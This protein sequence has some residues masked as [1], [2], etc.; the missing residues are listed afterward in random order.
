M[1][2]N[3]VSKKLNFNLYKFFKGDR[4]RKSVLVVLVL[5][6]FLGFV[7]FILPPS[8]AQQQASMVFWGIYPHEFMPSD[9]TDV[10]FC[11]QPNGPD[12]SIN[13][14]E[15]NQH[16]FSINPEFAVITSMDS[17]VY[18]TPAP[19]SPAVSPAV[20]VGDY[21]VTTNGT[22]SKVFIQYTPSIQKKIPWGET[23]CAH[24][25]LQTTSTPNLVTVLRFQSPFA[26]TVGYPGTIGVLAQTPRVRPPA[27]STFPSSCVAGPPQAD[28][29]IYTGNAVT[30]G[31][32]RCDTT[33]TPGHWT[34]DANSATGGI[35]SINGD[36]T[37]AQVITVG[38]SGT[39]PN[40]VTSA[41]TT[42]IN[43]PNAYQGKA[44]YDI[45]RDFGASGS[46][47]TT[48]GSISTG[49]NTLTLGGSFSC[50]NGQGILVKGAGAA[51]K[52]LVTTITSGCGTLSLVLGTNASTTVSGVT[53][54]HDDSAAINTAL[55]TV[56][57]A[58]GGNIFFKAGIYRANGALQ[59][60]C[61]SILCTPIYNR[62]S[63]GTTRIGLTGE[64]TTVLGG[65]LAIP[66]T[67]TI[68]DSSDWDG[69]ATNYSAILSAKT[70]SDTNIIADS[71]FNYLQVGI[72]GIRFR[73][74]P[75]PVLTALQFN[76][77]Q[78][79]DLEDVAIDQGE[80]L[81]F[82]DSAGFTVLTQPT[83]V[84]AVGILMPGLN[85]VYGGGLQNVS[86]IGY[87]TAIVASDNARFY[88][89]VE[90]AQNWIA[91]QIEANPAIV[92]GSVGIYEAHTGIL[93]TNR[94]GTGFGDAIQLTGQSELYTGTGI[95][96]DTPAGNRIVD[97]SNIASGSI[98]M[99]ENGTA[100]KGE[101]GVTGGHS[102]GFQHHELLT[103]ENVIRGA[104]PKQY[105]HSSLAAS[106]GN[107]FGLYNDLDNYAIFSVSGS[108]DATTALR[109]KLRIYTA[110]GIL[111]ETID[112]ATTI[113]FKPNT[114]LVGSMDATTGL[115]MTKDVN[116]NG[117]SLGLTVQTVSLTAGGASAL[118]LAL[119]NIVEG[120]FGA[121]NTTLSF[122][123]LLPGYYTIALIQDGTGSR[124]VTW[125][126]SVKWVGGTAPTLSTG[127][128][129]KDIFHFYSTGTTV[130]EMSRALDVR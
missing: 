33:G 93:I 115:T 5:A 91:L 30:K 2:I 94:F 90:L 49:T 47:A 67:G 13:E 26:P 18:L 3:A 114:T 56:G 106:P 10:N 108:A 101:L 96:W 39:A 7:D 124:T 105:F 120:T 83:N 17:N 70:Y 14:S 19:N 73:G 102:S 1:A 28:L 71:T 66:I 122:T 55:A 40:V 82:T 130:N 27:D 112:A 41:G 25:V 127:A 50:T 6:C 24:G 92:S 128:G 57:T 119:G 51:A 84:R 95:W 54:Q 121:G 78:G 100:A 32:Y 79:L 89:S 97:A 59:S 53:V 46:G 80:A 31:L 116:I 38:T 12:Q 109:N 129:K 103:Q 72:N 87:Y 36:A 69:T 63:A 86:V 88:G 99:Y 75:N 98:I 23:V 45:Q 44:R 43:F 64:G 11:F 76:N 29:F 20:T 110:K 48:S 65:S 34:L 22:N 4:V 123:N 58:G 111:L 104:E 16:I 68:I 125:P 42:T 126:A 117:A 107:Q 21:N 60:N 81:S 77:G 9:T 52:H 15:S 118:N 62:L 35:L 113:D 37:N 74:K 85:N 8:K 61:N